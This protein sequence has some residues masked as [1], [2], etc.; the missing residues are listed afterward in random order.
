MTRPIN[1]YRLACGC[2]VWRFRRKW[3]PDR[4]CT[5]HADKPTAAL[6]YLRR[7]TQKA[8]AS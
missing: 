1:A 3:I 4:V 5:T 2:H 7:L 8:I 6:D